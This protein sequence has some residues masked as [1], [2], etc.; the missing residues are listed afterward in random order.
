MLAAPAVL[1]APEP[2]AP[3]A[4]ASVPARP[5]PAAA[6]LGGVAPAGLALGEATST[7]GGDAEVGWP[8]AVSLAPDFDALVFVSVAAPSEPA[9]ACP[10][11]SSGAAPELAN[12]PPR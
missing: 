12:G 2:G 10:G 1:A 6:V 4:A 8:A 9:E 5:V 7:P 3:E 11:G